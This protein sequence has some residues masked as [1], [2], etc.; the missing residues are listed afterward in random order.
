M[1]GIVGFVDTLKTSSSET[2]HGTVQGMAAT[3]IHRGPD[4]GG[5]WVDPTCGVALGHRRLSILDLS[6]E[7]HQPMRSADG[8]FVVVFNGEIYNFLELREELESDGRVFRGTS[9][10]EVLLEGFSRWGFPQTLTKCVGMFA[11]AVWDRSDRVLYLARD[12]M[13][14][15]PLYYG[16]QGNVFVF[17]SELKAL[18]SHPQW[19]ADI[20][21]DALT[22][23]MRYGY[24]PAPHCIYRGI[25]KLPPGAFLTLYHANFRP[26]DI[27]V[28]RVYWSARQA[29]ESGSAAPFAGSDAEAIT[30]LEALLRRSIKLQMVADVPLGAFLSGGIDSSTV[31]ALMQAQSSRPVKT[32]SIGFSEADYNEAP[33]AKAV[34]EH[35]GTDHTELY[36]SSD[37]AINLIPSLSRVYDEPFGDSSQIPTCLVAQLAR[38]DVT[39][40]LSGDGGDE[41]FCGYSRYDTADYAWKTLGSLPK[42]ARRGVSTLMSA[43]PSSVLNGALQLSTPSLSR[44]RRSRSEWK[45]VASVLQESTSELF[46]R[47]YVSEWLEPSALVSGA[48][49]PPDAMTDKSRWARL[50]D[51]RHRMMYIDAIS[52]LPDDILVKVD[53]AGMSVSLETRM[54]LLDHRIVEFAW[55]VP[56]RLKRRDGRGK[57]LLRQVLYKYVPSR[58]V[59]RPKMGFGLPIA[60]WLRGP[61]RDWAQTLLAE[62]RLKHETY[63]NATLVRRAW[64]EHLSGNVDQHSLLWNVL[65]FQSW[66]ESTRVS[67]APR[68]MELVST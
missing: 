45:N 60:A 5:S 57:W 41:L 58:L 63:F 54:P 17:G 33:Q 15:K 30:A 26:G 7:G 66:L 35:L 40:S 31:V 48:T 61:L 39:V 43:M 34:A 52:Y 14:E 46:Y 29:A 42:V 4:D 2:L 21:R 27:P 12:R 55:S 53:R 11:L 68:V 37:E 16:W 6:P 8:R 25:H 9:D 36:I 51:F 24:V 38:R 56:L 59:D 22:L 20:D 32:F 49:E 62:S 44:R 18:R 28:P 65:M 50:P 64:N 67:S 23:L 19:R 3:L 1:C 10:T 47:L 13:G